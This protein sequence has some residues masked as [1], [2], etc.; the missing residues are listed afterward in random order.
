MSDI[1]WQGSTAGEGSEGAAPRPPRV[2]LV[3]P[4]AS[5]KSTVARALRARGI[6]A[7][8]VAQEHSVVPA[9]WRHLEPDLLVYLDVEYGTVRRRRRIS[10]GPGRLEAQKAALAP[11]RWAAGLYVPTDGLTVDQVVARILQELERAHPAKP[12]CPRA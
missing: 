3:G 12:G 9:L 7:H 8:A 10:W 2:I 5:G 6:D 4:C 11:A 1:R